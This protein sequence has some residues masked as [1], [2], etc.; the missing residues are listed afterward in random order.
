[1]G[2]EGNAELHVQYAVEVRNKF[3]ILEQEPS[4]E[5]Y[6]RFINKIWKTAKESLEAVP[7]R[8][9]DQSFSEK[10]SKKQAREDMEKAY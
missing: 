2:L 1:M 8:N 7:K 5:M 6:E 4:T 10:K 3:Q 9:K